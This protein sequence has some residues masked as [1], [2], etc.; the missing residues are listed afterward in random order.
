MSDY[1]GGTAPDYDTYLK[2]RKQTMDLNH[3]DGAKNS[4]GSGTPYGQH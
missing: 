1:L 3:Q 4:I 2:L